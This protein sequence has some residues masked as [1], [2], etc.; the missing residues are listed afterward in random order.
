MASA[1]MPIEAQAGSQDL[2]RFPQFEW[3]GEGYKQ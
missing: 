1:I 3:V 2:P